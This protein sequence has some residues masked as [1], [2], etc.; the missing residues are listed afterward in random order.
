[1]PILG[2]VIIIFAD[3]GVRDQKIWTSLFYKL[4]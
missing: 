3:I 2:G 1:M 4:N